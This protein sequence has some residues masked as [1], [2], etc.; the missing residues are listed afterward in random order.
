MCSHAFSLRADALELQT[1]PP[2]A[3]CIVQEGDGIVPDFED[4]N[5]NPMKFVGS[6]Q[7]GNTCNLGLA[8]QL[9]IGAIGVCPASVPMS[10]T[11]VAQDSLI[12]T[13]LQ[14]CPPAAVSCRHV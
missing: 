11:Y 4:K 1:S 13:Y 7:V 10:C 8:L 12:C 6:Q 9:A 14:V 2:T 5:P 3:H